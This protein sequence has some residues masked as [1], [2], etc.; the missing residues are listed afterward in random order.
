MTRNGATETETAV[1]DL[2]MA[3]KQIQV[4]ESLLAIFY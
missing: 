1:N 3:N 4:N 2:T